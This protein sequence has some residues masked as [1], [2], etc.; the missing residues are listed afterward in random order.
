[1]HERLKSNHIHSAKFNINVL[2]KRASLE[3][4]MQVNV[5]AFKFISLFGD[6]SQLSPQWSWPPQP[7]EDVLPSHTGSGFLGESQSDGRPACR[8]ATGE[9]GGTAARRGP[10]AHSI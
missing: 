5:K 9:P 1:M 4:M 8:S 6:V 10:T 7:P 3:I 2:N